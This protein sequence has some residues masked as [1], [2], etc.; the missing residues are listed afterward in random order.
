MTVPLNTHINILVSLQL[1][2][3]SN[4]VWLHIKQQTGAATS[5]GD[6]WSSWCIPEWSSCYCHVPFQCWENSPYPQRASAIDALGLG[7]S[8][9]HHHNKTCHSAPG[10]HLAFVL[11]SPCVC[12]AGSCSL[13]RFPFPSFCSNAYPNV[14]SHPQG[15]GVSCFPVCSLS[16]YQLLDPSCLEGEG[17]QKEPVG[18]CSAWGHQ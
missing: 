4:C 9:H 7:L 18:C 2:S 10:S 16:L 3:L 6:S 8:H 11:W 1:Y 17:S 13:M 5:A 15:I 14:F 12:A